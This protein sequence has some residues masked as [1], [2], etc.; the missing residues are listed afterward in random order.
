M[1]GPITMIFYEVKIWTLRFRIKYRRSLYV[2]IWN[3]QWGQHLEFFYL[4]VLNFPFLTYS[5]Q[6]L[7]EHSC[8]HMVDWTRGDLPPPLTAL[9]TVIA[10]GKVCI[11]FAWESSASLRNC[12]IKY[13]NF[14]ETLKITFFQC[15]KVTQLFMPHMG[16]Y[17]MVWYFIR[18]LRVHIFTS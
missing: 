3:T 17:P 2:P 14:R 5:F 10:T 18:N 6:H 7:L 16:M 8:T 12:I 4:W 11:K 15:P 1:A 9:V 13:A